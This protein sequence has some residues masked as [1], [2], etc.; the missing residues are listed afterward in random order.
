MQV[1]PSDAVDPVVVPPAVRRTV[2][3]AHEQAMQNGEED[4]TFEREPVL[5]F[6]GKFFDHGAAAGLV[7]QTL[8][9]KGGPEPPHLRHH[10][11]PVMDGVHHHRLGGKPRA[12]AQ[13]L[14]QLTALAQIVVAAQRGDHLLT[15]LRAV[16]PALDDLR[17]GA[18]RRGLLRNASG[19]SRVVST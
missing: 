4:G 19:N 14:F 9:H 11:A 8:E 17:I 12:R 2:G 18:P 15:D 1:E 13:Q 3:P 7:P 16:A 5:A 10:R 6:S